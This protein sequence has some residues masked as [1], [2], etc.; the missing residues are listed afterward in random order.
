[1]QL[2]SVYLYSNKVDVFT[3]LGAWQLERYRRVYNRTLKIYRSADNRIDFRVKN[4][5]EKPINISGSA[6]VFKLIGYENQ[7]LI[8]EKDCEIIS[9]QDGK[10]F[11]DLSETE[12]FEIP[13]GFYNYTLVAETRQTIDST[14]YRVV[15]RTPLYIDG[16]YEAVAKIEV[17]GDVSGKAVNSLLVDIFDYTNP[18]TT[19]YVGS[20]FYTS[21]I[22]DARPNST[23]GKS[24]HTFQLYMKDYTGRVQIQGS[25]DNGAT[26]KNWSD[27]EVR[28]YDN[29]NNSYV[30]ITGKWNWFRIRHSPVAP[31]SV[32]SF[33]VAQTILGNYIVNVGNKGRGYIENQILR[34]SGARLGGETTTNDL[35]ITVTSVDSRGGITGF[36][37]TG[38]SYNGVRTFTITEDLSITVGSLDK[39]LYR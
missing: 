4:S 12:L 18:G 20:P 28:D 1:M 38:V 35:I 31:L 34:V 5:D 39:V 22:I 21:S 8:L 11:I 15:S 13:E 27:I 14:E 23:S 6:I 9:A 33:T 19:G 16:Q 36:T 30:N 10:L 32:A 25:L 26:P 2:N 29:A 17:R 3:N 37:Y 24:F 7:E